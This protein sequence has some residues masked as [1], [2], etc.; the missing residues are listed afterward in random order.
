MKAS[1]PWRISRQ[2]TAIPVPRMRE[3]RVPAAVVATP[4]EAQ[5]PPTRCPR[6]GLMMTVAPAPDSRWRTMGLEARAV[7]ARSGAWA[8]RVLLAGEWT[9]M[10]I[11]AWVVG[12]LVALIAAFVLWL[13]FLDWNTMRGPL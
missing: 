3:Q 13:Y 7:L 1:R 4:V 10:R 6:R 5:S 12:L 11:L 2:Y 9:W 8:H